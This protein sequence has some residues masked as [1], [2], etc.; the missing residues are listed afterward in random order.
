[1]FFVLRCLFFS[2]FLSAQMHDLLDALSQFARSESE[3]QMANMVSR[4]DYNGFYSQRPK[5]DSSSSYSLPSPLAASHPQRTVRHPPSALLRT[6]ST[7]VP[8]ARPVQSGS[9]PTP[10][11]AF[12]SAPAPTPALASRPLP[13]GAPT[14]PSYSS[15][16]YTSS[17]SSVLAPPP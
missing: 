16:T 11:P 2:L 1:M 7:L 8:P 3:V 9:A 14:G 4:L 5:V 6:T 12:A 17:R 13:P 15:H 10:A